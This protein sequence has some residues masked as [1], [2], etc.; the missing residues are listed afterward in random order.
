MDLADYILAEA[1][2]EEVVVHLEALEAIPG[3][4]VTEVY[5]VAGAAEL[6]IM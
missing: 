3:L 5:M 6:E 1:A 4:V 2:E